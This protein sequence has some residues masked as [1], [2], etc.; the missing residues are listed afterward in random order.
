MWIAVAVKTVLQSASLAIDLLVAS[1]RK[2]NNSV[3]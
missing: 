2:I 1:D 3:R